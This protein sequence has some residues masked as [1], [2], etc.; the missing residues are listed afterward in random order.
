MKFDVAVIG[1]GMSGLMASIYLAERGFSTVVVSRGNPI[2][3]ISSGCIDI[4][5]TGQDTRKAIDSFPSEHP[6]H[7]VGK[8]ALFDS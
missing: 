4:A 3:S 5:G 1:S 6:Y 7:K 2:C 8:Q